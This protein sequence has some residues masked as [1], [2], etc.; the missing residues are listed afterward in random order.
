MS[1]NSLFKF[2]NS[3]PR[4]LL[5]GSYAPDARRSSSA[6]AILPTL[7]FISAFSSSSPVADRLRSVLGSLFSDG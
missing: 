7:D 6:F 3:E 4:R 2:S 1:S 5:M